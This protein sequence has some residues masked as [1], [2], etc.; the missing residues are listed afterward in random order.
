MHFPHDPRLLAWE[1]WNEVPAEFGPFFQIGS[2][3]G[4]PD[5]EIQSV[6]HIVLT[7]QRLRLACY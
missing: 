4:V 7:F 1:G 2:L 5:G 6:S 3:L